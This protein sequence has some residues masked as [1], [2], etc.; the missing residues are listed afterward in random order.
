MTLLACLI[1]QKTKGDIG[2]RRGVVY[3]E[4]EGTANVVAALPVSRANA[5]F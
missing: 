5:G 4:E 2:N 1:S 3:P